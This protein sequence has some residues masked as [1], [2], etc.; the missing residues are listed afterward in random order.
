MENGREN[1]MARF[2][3][4]ALDY[5]RQRQMLIPCFDDF[6]SIAAAAAASAKVS[7]HILDIGA[8]TGLFSAFMLEKY[9][10][11]HL[12][13]IDISDKMLE[14]AQS[15]FERHPKV[16]Y[17]AD[18]YTKHEFSGSFD[19]VVSSL[20]IHHLSDIEK[21]ELYRKAYALLNPGG[22]FVNADQVLGSTPYLETLY[23]DD[24]KMKVEASGLPR[25]ARSAAYERTKLDKMAPLDAQLGWLTEA[26][27]A[28]VDCIYKYYNFVVMF[29][30]KTSG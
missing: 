3:E 18:D 30:R 13:L 26:G 28:D 5:D 23:K 6:Y 10:G 14:V 19:I 12:T 9:P 29:G 24:W 1:V 15:R 22:V 21:K 25:E 7:P 20:S 27:F 17:V 11:A 16:A 4:I 2:N 8:G